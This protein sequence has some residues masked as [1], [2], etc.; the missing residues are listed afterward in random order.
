[1]RLQMRQPDAGAR[2]LLPRVQPLKNHENLLPIL[3]FDAD[4]VVAD[5]KLPNG[6]VAAGRNVGPAADG[7]RGT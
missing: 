6:I 5:R 2:I 1:M 7:R 4:A 3:P